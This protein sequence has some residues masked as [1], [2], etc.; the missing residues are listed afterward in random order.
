MASTM[1]KGS[2]LEVG[3]TDELKFFNVQLSAGSD[4]DLVHYMDIESPKTGVQ[5]RVY[6]PFFNDVAWGVYTSV[7]A[8]IGKKIRWAQENVA[9]AQKFLTDSEI[10][11]IRSKQITMRLSLAQIKMCLQAR[12]TQLRS[13][14]ISRRRRV[15]ESKK[16]EDDSGL[17]SKAQTLRRLKSR[18]QALEKHEDGSEPKRVIP[19]WD[20][21][22]G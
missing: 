6:S 4:T 2:D 20:E 3:P 5:L 11:K 13:L 16:H 17:E 15:T 1:P 21:E 8:E 10:E 19:E 14:E 9:K 22:S 12:E 7:V 18:N